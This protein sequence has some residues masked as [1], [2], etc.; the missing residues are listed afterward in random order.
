MYLKGE[1]NDDNDRYYKAYLIESQLINDI[2][3]PLCHC[4]FEDDEKY[5]L[6]DSKC[7]CKD[8]CYHNDCFVEF[9]NKNNKGYN[10][11]KTNIYTFSCPTCRN[12]VSVDTHFIPDIKPITPIKPIIK[13]PKFTPI[14]FDYNEYN[15]LKKG[16]DSIIMMKHI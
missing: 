15:I 7:R 4:S 9:Y 6:I 16:I 5:N 11:S 2:L 10:A 8:S 13:S 1:G 3:C 12:N 14:N